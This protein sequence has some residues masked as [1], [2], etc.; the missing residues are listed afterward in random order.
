MPTHTVGN[1]LGRWENGGRILAQSQ[2][3][4]FTE[5]GRASDTS[6]IQPLVIALYVH[7]SNAVRYD[8]LPCLKSLRDRQT[9]SVDME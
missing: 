9:L 8:L 7:W 3:I 4:S 5:H 6:S 2:E 1:C